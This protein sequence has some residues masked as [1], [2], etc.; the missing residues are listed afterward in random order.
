MTRNPPSPVTVDL[1]QSLEDTAVSAARDIIERWRIIDVE[2]AYG[3]GW[4]TVEVAQ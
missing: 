4:T 1:L 2:G 3:I